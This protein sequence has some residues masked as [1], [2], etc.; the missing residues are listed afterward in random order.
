VPHTLVEDIFGIANGCLL[1]SLG[2]HL[3]HEARLITGGVAGVALL[4]L[5]PALSSGQPVYMD[6]PADLCAV[7]VAVGHA[8]ILR[9]CVATLAIMLL[10][11]VVADN[12]VIARITMPMA[13]IVGERRWVS[14]FWP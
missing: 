8:Y 13:A 7:L 6:Q 4:L 10:V 11:D 3:L 5:Y 2:L 14:A 1:I 9:T 12:M